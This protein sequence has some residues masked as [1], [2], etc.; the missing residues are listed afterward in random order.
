V[1]ERYGTASAPSSLPGR[2]LVESF[3]GLSWQLVP[4]T[5][6]DLSVDS[7]VLTSVSCLSAGTCTAVGA[8]GPHIPANSSALVER[9]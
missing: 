9:S 2:T 4:S 5:N 7:D 3:N 1:G 8:F 6:G